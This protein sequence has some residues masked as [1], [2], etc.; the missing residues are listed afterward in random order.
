VPAGPK[1]R[2]TATNSR[3]LRLSARTLEMV[4]AMALLMAGIA[5]QASVLLGDGAE[6]QS[7]A[8][9]YTQYK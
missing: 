8:E 9:V 4:S 3:K 1:A 6:L 5:W 7:V 2:E